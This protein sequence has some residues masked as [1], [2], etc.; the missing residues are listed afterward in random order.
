MRK[1]LIIILFLFC[2][3][4]DSSGLS[5]TFTE[6]FIENLTPG[7]TY[8]IKKIADYPY[9]V[10]NN[11]P[12]RNKIKVQPVKPPDRHLRRGF[13]RIPQTEWIFIDPC[14]LVLKS[15]EKGEADIIITIPDQVEYYNKKYQVN[16]L[17]ETTPHQGIALGMA[18][19]SILLFSTVKQ[20]EKVEALTDKINLNYSIDPSNLY[21]TN[22]K[23]RDTNTKLKKEYEVELVNKGDSKETFYC[24]LI[25]VS[26]SSMPLRS[27]YSDIPDL[28]M[29]KLKTQEITLAGKEK[30]KLKFQIYLPDVK[31]FM[32]K[33]YEFLIHVT[34]GYRS[35]TSGKF[36][37][38]F[39]DL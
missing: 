13:T 35:N 5:T 14:D 19:E 27:G 15:G 17:A 32:N 34:S 20:N 10:H 12:S 11:S 9:N 22:L 4:H 1:V 24:K 23:V 33:K 16:I 36:L 39:I 7:G 30:A 38:I 8:S 18:V 29:I 28:F 25:K 37:K 21:I 2:F 6:V 31:Q 3:Y 26:D